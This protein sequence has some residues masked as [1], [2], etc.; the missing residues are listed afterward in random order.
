LVAGADLA[1]LVDARLPGTAVFLTAA[2]GFLAAPLGFLT[3]GLAFFTVLA[4][5]T[6]LTAGDGFLAVAVVV[7][8]V[9]FFVDG[10]GLLLTDDAGVSDDFCVLG[11]V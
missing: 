3:A 7:D 10:T 2:V 9:L 1:E 8:E 5:V 6:V 4:V 11:M